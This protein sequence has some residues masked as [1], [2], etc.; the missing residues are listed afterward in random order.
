[1]SVPSIQTMNSLA[2]NGPDLKEPTKQPV[3]KKHI[4]Q[5]NPEER[6][7]REQKAARIEQNRAGHAGRTRSSRVN[8]SDAKPSTIEMRLLEKKC[9]FNFWTDFR[10]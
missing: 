3:R 9:K 10:S 4:S 8:T 7:A 2:S 1:M 6:A 5:C